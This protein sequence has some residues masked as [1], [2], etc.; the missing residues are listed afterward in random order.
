MFGDA[1]AQGEEEPPCSENLCSCSLN[2]YILTGLKAAHRGAFIYWIA[3]G[4]VCTVFPEDFS[5]REKKG[6]GIKI[7]HP[8]F[9]L[10]FL[11]H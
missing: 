7:Q 4:S 1:G 2:G 9:F 5:T 3:S 10:H 8:Y 6:G 11:S